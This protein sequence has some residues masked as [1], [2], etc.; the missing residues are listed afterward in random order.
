MRSAGGGG[1]WRCCSLCCGRFLGGRASTSFLIA[2]VAN[3]VLDSTITITITTTTTT[4][5][6]TS[7]TIASSISIIGNTSTSTSASTGTSTGTS[8][9]INAATNILIHTITIPAITIRIITSTIT[10]A[11]RAAPRIGDSSG[12]RVTHHEP[13]IGIVGARAA[14]RLRGERQRAGLLKPI[15]KA[16]RRWGLHALAEHAGPRV[17][18][19]VQHQARRRGEAR[20]PGKPRRGR[21]PA[22]VAGR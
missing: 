14:W 17:A 21:R 6:I 4:T 18:R 16:H 13:I 22:V 2:G 9:S 7:I 15:P 11:L 20:C 5:S 19:R 1:R 10:H 12:C 8:T 3:A